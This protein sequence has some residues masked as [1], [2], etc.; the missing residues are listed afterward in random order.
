MG[1]AP[2][3]KKYLDRDVKRAE[4]QN[5]CLKWPQTLP[6]VLAKLAHRRGEPDGPTWKNCRPGRLLPCEE[7]SGHGG[8]RGR[9]AGHAGALRGREAAGRRLVCIVAIQRSFRQALSASLR[10]QLGDLRRKRDT[11]LVTCG[12]P[13][14][15]LHWGEGLELGERE[16]GRARGIRPPCYVVMLRASLRLFPSVLA[17]ISPHF[18]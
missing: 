15:S 11:E 5:R 3:T 16:G 17:R 13:T 10:H 1:Q 2:T 9:L 8:A 12:S 6:S 7:G 4:V 18:H 14:A